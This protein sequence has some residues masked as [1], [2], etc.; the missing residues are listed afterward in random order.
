MLK[1]KPWKVEQ[2]VSYLLCHEKHLVTRTDT[3]ISPLGKASTERFWDYSWITG[4][5]CFM[6]PNS[7]N[8]F[9]CNRTTRSLLS[10]QFCCFSTEGFLS[11]TA[12]RYLCSFALGSP[13]IS[14][15][16]GIMVTFLFIVTLLKCD[17][18]FCRWFL[19]YSVLEL[20]VR[21][22][23]LHLQLFFYTIEL[24]RNPVALSHQ[25]CFSSRFR[26]R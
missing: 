18:L 8:V 25:F 22:S 10:C 5:I 13:G 6:N 19:T 24:L 15:L 23:I 12:A 11:L 3:G 7:P 9:L 4:W 2:H 26:H 21:C 1:V 14:V 20:S 17:I 16:L